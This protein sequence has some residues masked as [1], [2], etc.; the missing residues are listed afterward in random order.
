MLIVRAASDV[1]VSLAVERAGAEDLEPRLGL[2]EAEDWAEIG[3]DAPALDRLLDLTA[4]AVHV[5]P[6]RGGLSA[7]QACF[8]GLPAEVSCPPEGTWVYAGVR[9]PVQQTEGRYFVTVH[10]LSGRVG[11]VVTTRLQV[12]R[13]QEGGWSA[14]P[15]V[16]VVG[17]SP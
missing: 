10:T 14:V 9:P 17:D 11:G 1:A 2:V 5:R 13:T 8:A 4:A 12:T 7:V 6:Q 16:S 3:I 15:T